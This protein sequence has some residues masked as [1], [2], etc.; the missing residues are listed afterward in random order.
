LLFGHIR[1]ILCYVIIVWLRYLEWEQSEALKSV[2][3]AT[4]SP[5]KQELAPGESRYRRVAELYYRVLS[6]PV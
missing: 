6:L 1:H 2:A 4:A 3:T 5:V